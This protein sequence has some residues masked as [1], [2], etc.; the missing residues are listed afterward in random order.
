MS[1]ICYL[2][3]GIPEL[4]LLRRQLGDAIAGRAVECCQD[5]P[6]LLGR[7]RQPRPQVSLALLAAP[8]R[9]VLER[10]LEQRIV[11]AYLPVV[12]LLDDDDEAVLALAHLLAPRLL[13]GLR[14]DPGVIKDVIGRIL[15][16]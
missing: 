16:R 13:T 14:Q 7:L 3:V 5:L 11:F 2:P 10:F 6:R 1:V 9:A 8:D 15:A 12:L 4:E